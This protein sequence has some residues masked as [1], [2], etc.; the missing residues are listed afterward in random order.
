ATLLLN[1]ADVF[2]EQRAT[3]NVHYNAL[4]YIFLHKLKY[5]KGILFLITN[6]V[7]TINK[8]I[9]SRIYLAL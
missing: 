7:K 6:W 1:K 3:N 4:I 5:Y 9:I 2:V 8:A